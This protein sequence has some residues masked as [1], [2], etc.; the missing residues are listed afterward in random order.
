MAENSIMTE[1]GD[2]LKKERETKRLSVQEVAERTKISKRYLVCI[3]N[4]DYDQLPPGPYAKGY[5]AAYARQVCGDETQALELFAAGQCA[6][7]NPS[8]TASS[9]ADGS[10]LDG[11]AT[12]PSNGNNGAPRPARKSAGRRILHTLREMMPERGKLR[13]PSPQES[14]D[15]PSPGAKAESLAEAMAPRTQI[16]KGFLFKGGLLSGLFFLGLSVLVLAG[17]GVYHLFYF[18]QRSETLVESQVPAPQPPATAASAAVKAEA[19]TAAK[20]PAGRSAPP[21]EV[22]AEKPEAAVAP[23]TA[24][25]PQRAPSKDPS[26][27]TPKPEA[28]TE[29]PVTNAAAA[30]EKAAASENPP[31]VAAA[32]V[33][34][35]PLPQ[36]PGTARGASQAAQAGSV[37]SAAPAPPSPTASQTAA[38]AA[39]AAPFKVIEASVCTAVSERMPVGASERFP[40]TTPKI[41]V[42]SLLSADD[43]PAKVRHIY[44][45]DGHKVSDV[46]LKVGSSYWRTWSF[47]TL[48]GQ[49]H[50]G[51]WHIDIATLDGRVLRRLHFAIE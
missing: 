28:L 34:E 19:A 37:A 35:P 18:Q 27:P 5:I 6:A 43:P 24:Q 36:R 15:R 22:V 2:Y 41:F 3:E 39:P 45:H 29:A 32:A 33:E 40:W 17:F 25:G 47:H 48:S 51:P 11:A 21:D 30:P 26:A 38:P 10:A 49:L 16:P 7:Q 42:W 20:P 12:S 46:I 13:P 14:Q 8:A 50:I 44:Y 4:G 1:V 23:K 9:G 31:P